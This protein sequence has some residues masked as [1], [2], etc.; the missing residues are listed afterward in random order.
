LIELFR[1]TTDP[2]GQDILIGVSWDLMWAA[3]VLAAVFLVGHAVWYRMR[4]FGGQAEEATPVAVPAGVPERIQRHSLPARV[5]HW[6]MSASMLALLFSAFVPIMDID[7]G[8]WLTI[9]WIAGVVLIATI[10]YHIIHAIGW[11]D[12]WAM[13]SVGPKFFKEGFAQLRHVLSSN[14]PEPP[15]AGK[16]PFDHRMYHHAIVVV[17]LSAVVTGVIMMMRIDT[18][19][20]ERNTYL[21]TDSMTGWVFAIHGFAGVSLILLIASH[22][23]FALRPEKR[24]ITWSMVRGWIGREDYVEHFDPDQWEVTGD[25]EAAGG[26]LADASVSAPLEDD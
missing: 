24:W 6:T 12:F 1:R 16:Y 5:F 18:P 8:G 14:A 10:V 23:Y 7:F 21:L 11:Q 22:I 19:F 25:R 26:A 17:S 4:S 2:W 15:K 9:H 13:M 3:I 20:F